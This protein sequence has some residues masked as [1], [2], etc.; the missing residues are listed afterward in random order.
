M[1]G[2]NVAQLDGVVRRLGEV[3]VDPSLWPDVLDQVS[4]AVGATGAALLQSDNR[5]PDIP[6]SPGVD[7]LFRLYF[8]GNWH[9][10]DIRAIRGVPLLRRDKVIFDQDILTPDEMRRDDL[11]GDILQSQG[12][13][14]F[15]GVGFRADTSLW[16]MSIQ[17]SVREGPFEDAD[18]RIFRKLSDHLTETATLSKAVEGANLNGVTNALE[19][20]KQPALALD[21]TGAVVSTNSSAE[22]VFDDWMRVTHRCLRIRDDQSRSA[23]DAV[24]RAV[25]IPGDGSPQHPSIVVRRGPKRPVIVRALPID[26][27]ASYPFLGA[28]TLLLLTDL[29]ARSRPEHPDLARIFG[30]TPAESRLAAEI[31][32]GFSLDETADRL[33]IARETAR[34]QLKT[35]MAK[36]DTHKQ[37][38]LVGLLSRVAR[39]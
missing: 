1:A 10:R 23:M 8:E 31:A 32:S 13:Q 14:W 24:L 16:A 11:Y 5:T 7:E 34:N 37:G 21:A 18:K 38:E 20:V 30:L 2:I 19:L 35:V 9:V 25:G 4:M 17:R 15:A 36:T 27:A 22:A 6:R 3:V 29:D 33:G 12:M 39:S 28:R 26:G